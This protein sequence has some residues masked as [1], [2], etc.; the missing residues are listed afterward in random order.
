V[1][2]ASAALVAAFCG[3]P[4]ARLCLAA[5][6][7]VLLLRRP[8]E[9]RGW[10][11]LACAG[12]FFFSTPL[13]HP[14]ARLLLPL[15]LTL[16]AL[17]GIA[18]GSA[19]TGAGLLAAPLPRPALAGLSA[20]I[21]AASAMSWTRT[22]PSDPWRPSDGAQRAAR[23][24]ALI[25]PEGTRTVVLGEP[26]LAFELHLGGRPAFERVLDPARQ[27]T[28]NEEPIYV[29]SGRYGRKAPA[30]RNGLVALGGRLAQ[31]GEVALPTPRDHRL[32]DDLRID[33]VKS[34]LTDP[35][36]AEYR[37]TVYRLDP[38]TQRTPDPD[39]VREEKR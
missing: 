4:A 5:I 35:D 23:A 20:V 11:L 30:L 15:D 2:V 16:C 21:V 27:L 28:G 12:V 14:Y 10:V 6:S 19:A 17:S 8:A 25:V 26:T 37:L 36:P 33:R 24:V 9:L 32:L 39:P 7:V 38:D 18:L 34:F 13:Y 1:V 31:I 3:A 29:V 22:S